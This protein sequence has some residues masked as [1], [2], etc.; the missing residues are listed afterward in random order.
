MSQRASYCG[1]YSTK[2]NGNTKR[3]RRGVIEL[4]S[5]KAGFC[6]LGILLYCSTTTVG[7]VVSG[8][9]TRCH[10]LIQIPSLSAKPLVISLSWRKVG[11]I[12]N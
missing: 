3:F 1:F 2:A 6:S 4:P 11:I 7:V 5:G 9:S 8:N 12:C 10:L